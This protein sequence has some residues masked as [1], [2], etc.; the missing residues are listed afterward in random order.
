MAT[1]NS[2]RLE[3]NTTIEIPIFM[4]IWIVSFIGFLLIILTDFGGF[5]KTGYYEGTRYSCIGC[6]YEAGFDLLALIIDLLFFVF[7]F[8]IA[9]NQQRHFMDIKFVEGKELQF[10]MLMS[11][12]IIILTIGGGIAFAVEYSEYEWW[13]ETSFYSS[14]ICGALII[15][16]SWLKLDKT[17][18]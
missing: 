18:V 7:I 16:F 3:D 4:M 17:K 14:I 2:N 10:I 8:L 15:L 11:L 5:Y 6:E 1:E 9:L 12:L 13:F